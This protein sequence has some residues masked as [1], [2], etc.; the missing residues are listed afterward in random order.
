MMPVS[1]IHQCSGG[2]EVNRPSNSSAQIVIRA[3]LV[4]IDWI[5]AGSAP[6]F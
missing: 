6:A 3:S 5:I 1:A 2:E 4:N